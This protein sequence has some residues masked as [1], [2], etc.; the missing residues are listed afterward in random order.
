MTTSAYT[1]D[2]SEI[3]P[4]A[5]TLSARHLEAG[6]PRPRSS[7]PG[8]PRSRPDR[9]WRRSEGA[10][11]PGRQPGHHDG[12]R[13]PGVR[14]LRSIGR[15]RARADH[16]AHPCR[17]GVSAG[18][19]PQ[20]RSTVQDDS[21]EAP[22]RAGRHGPARH[23]GRRALRRIRRQPSDALSPRNTHGRTTSGRL[24]CAFQA[25]TTKLNLI[26]GKAWLETLR[27]QLPRPDRMRFC[28]C[29]GP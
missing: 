24:E 26:A 7:S 25:E 2:V 20:R 17:A 8:Q 10:R 3:P 5:R 6:P 18:P 11:R 19:G 27:S 12:K 9:T 1:A 15:V 14:H 21:S 28:A 23:Q 29:I 13:A 4:R 16:R 22:S